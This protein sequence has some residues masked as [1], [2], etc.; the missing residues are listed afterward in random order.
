MSFLGLIWLPILYLS[1][2][3]PKNFP[4]FSLFILT[5][6]A[7]STSA[8]IMR[9]VAGEN[10]MNSPQAEPKGSVM[11]SNEERALKLLGQGIDPGVVANAIGLTPA[12]ISQM[13]SQDEFSKA[14]ATARYENLAAHTQRDNKYDSLE[15]QI[16]EKLK[17]SLCM[18]YDPMKLARLLQVVNGAKR[19]GTGIQELPQGQA[20][21]IPLIMPVQIIQQ[22]AKNIHN[23]VVRAGNQDL[24]TV[25]SG[26]MSK[27]LEASKVPLPSIQENQH[28]QTTLSP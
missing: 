26:Q 18:I 5:P 7:K 9:P 8:R 11:N 13:L 6:S 27:L 16:L 10:I 28:V 3:F 2:N 21:T 24:V 14:L 12:A 15:D 20:Q 22:F 4:N 23:Q 19:R 1:T 25:Q 17:E